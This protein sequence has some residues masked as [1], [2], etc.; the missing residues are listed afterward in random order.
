MAKDKNVSSLASPGLLLKEYE[1]CQQATASIDAS[2][3]QT[4]SVIGVGSVAAFALV[5]GKET[6][7]VLALLVGI[8]SSSLVFIW[9]MAAK[10]WWDI[11]H[12]KFMRMRH[13]ESRLGILQNRY[14]AHRDSQTEIQVAELGGDKTAENQLEELNQFED[15]RAAKRFPRMGVQ[16]WF[17]LFPFLNVALWLALIVGSAWSTVTGPSSPQ[18]PAVP[19]RTLPLEGLDPI[20]KTLL[21]LGIF[22][23]VALGGVMHHFF[24]P[25]TVN[26]DVGR[27]A[28]RIREYRSRHFPVRQKS[29]VSIQSLIQ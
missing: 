23:V 18:S 2:I 26:A 25:R 17:R 22:A 8:L 10:R 3:W 14:I 27:I 29:K 1:L 16:K 13:I 21:A 15:A 6:P 4:S 11:Q 20:H 28:R 9:W 7:W 12:T 19:T 24:L 5:I